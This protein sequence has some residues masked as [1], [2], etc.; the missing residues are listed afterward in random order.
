MPEVAPNCHMEKI[1]MRGVC[2]DIRRFLRH[3]TPEPYKAQMCVL[4]ARVLVQMKVQ[5][6]LEEAL[7]S[8]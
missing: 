1:E 5:Q 7:N 3:T 2:F 8:P 4:L 6:Q